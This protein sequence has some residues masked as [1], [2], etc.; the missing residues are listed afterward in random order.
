MANQ[1]TA[2][3]ITTADAA[4]RRFREQFPTMN[5]TDRQKIVNLFY[6]IE[7]GSE[8]RGAARE[9]KIWESKKAPCKVAPVSAV[10]PS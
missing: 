7:E 6:C 9:R 8:K 2:Q 4:K 3:P 1:H 5:E 10:L